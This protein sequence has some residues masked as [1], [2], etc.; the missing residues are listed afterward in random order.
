MAGGPC[1]YSVSPKAYLLLDFGVCWDRDLSFDN[2]N[3][4]VETNFAENLRT[5]N[6]SQICLSLESSLQGA[7]RP[8]RKNC[9]TRLVN[10]VL[11]MKIE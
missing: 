11:M 8:F 10:D 9:E 7:S 5:H 3:T 6:V 2:N 4:A 1:D